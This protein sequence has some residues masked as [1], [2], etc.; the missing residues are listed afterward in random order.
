MIC[1][2]RLSICW[3]VLC[4]GAPVPAQAQSVNTIDAAPSAITFVATQ[5]G[6]PAEGG[7]KRFTARVDFDPARLAASQAR[8]D[9][10][11]DSFESGVTEVDTEIKRRAWFN[12]A[13][14]PVATFVASAVRSLGANRYEATGKMT[15][16][17]RTRE[18][19]VPFMVR[20]AGDV[21]VFE[22]AFTL[23]RLDYGIGEG[24]WAD[25]ETVA[26]EV[27]IRFKLTGT[28]RK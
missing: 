11:L 13:Q 9:V 16:K 22:G 19:T 20:Q 26:D 24:P 4:L 3:L 14:F 5:M 18:V 28:S 25:T 8:I 15:I 10:E 23:K 17:G 1:V 21:T 2:R 6:V 12:T 27:Q 7:F